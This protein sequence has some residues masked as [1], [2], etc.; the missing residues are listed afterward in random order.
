M[1]RLSEEWAGTMAGPMFTACE[2]AG[3]AVDVEPSG[4]RGS[5]VTTR[6]AC[7]EK[8]AACCREI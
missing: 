6:A 2:K 1:I 3:E 7:L 8:R 5:S 4:W